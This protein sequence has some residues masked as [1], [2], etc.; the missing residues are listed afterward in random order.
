[1]ERAISGYDLS[2]GNTDELKRVIKRNLSN[3]LIKKTKQSP[4]IVPVVVEI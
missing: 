4:M 3:Y 1:M 2:R